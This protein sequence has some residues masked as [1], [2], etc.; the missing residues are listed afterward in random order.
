MDGL[1][2]RIRDSYP[3]DSDLCG[4]IGVIRSIHVSCH[5]IKNFI[6][7]RL[8]ILISYFLNS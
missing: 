6:N 8:T 3:H 5:H 1:M 4:A 2:V 7:Q